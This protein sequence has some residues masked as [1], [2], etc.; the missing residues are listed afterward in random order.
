M[1][2][3]LDAVVNLLVPELQARGVFKTAYR[4]GTLREKL[5]SGRGARLAGSHPAPAS[6]GRSDEAQRTRLVRHPDHLAIAR[7]A[8]LPR[9]AVPAAYSSFKPTQKERSLSLTRSAILVEYLDS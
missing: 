5:F 4:E 8:G 3:S 6:A 2:E 1:P 9:A 7:M